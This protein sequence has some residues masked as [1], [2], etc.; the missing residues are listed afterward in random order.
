MFGRNS[1]KVGPDVGDG[2]LG[3][4]PGAQAELPRRLG[5]AVEQWSSAGTAAQGLGAAMAWRSGE[6]LGFGA[7]RWGG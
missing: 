7:A 1:G 2:G 3:E 4:A 5:L 6:M